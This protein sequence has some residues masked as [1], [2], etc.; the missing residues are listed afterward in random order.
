MEV[1]DVL[2]K[3]EQGVMIPIFEEKKFRKVLH[4]LYPL[5]MI[6][7]EEVKQ[8]MKHY[9]NQGKIFCSNK[10]MLFVMETKNRGLQKLEKISLYEMIEQFEH[11]EVLN[12]INQENKLLVKNKN[13]YVTGMKFTDEL[14]RRKREL[15]SYYLGSRI[16]ALTQIIRNM[17]G[18]SCD[19]D[20]C[21][22][23]CNKCEVQLHVVLQNNTKLQFI[24][25]PEEENNQSMIWINI[26]N[27]FWSEIK[28][29]IISIISEKVRLYSEQ[30]KLR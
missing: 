8:I 5:I 9:Y 14:L 1:Y 22:Y 18:V 2:Y 10:N 28:R 12:M 19:A 20:A 30:Q 16:Q 13:K 26:T 27:R 23:I 25:T 11:N 7:E 24:I 15:V 6:S 3:N 4:K 21:T 17:Y 29:E